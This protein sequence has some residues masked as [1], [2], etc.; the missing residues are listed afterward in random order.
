MA[1]KRM[2]NRDNLPQPLVD[3]IALENSKYSPGDSDI[4]VTQLIGSPRIRLL[5]K[6][7]RD[8][9]EEDASDML[10]RFFGQIAHGVIS[11]LPGHNRFVEER[12][13]MDV[14]G[15]KVGGQPDDYDENDII[16]DWKVTSKYAVKDGVKREWSDQIRSYAE[17]LSANGFEPKGGKIV[18]IL[19]DSKADEPKVKVLEV[20][21]PPHLDTKLYLEERVIIHQHAEAHG[22]VACSPEER[23]TK[24]TVWAV[25][26]KGRKSAVKLHSTKQD[27]LVMSSALNHNNKNHSVV[28]RPG[29][30][31][32]CVKYCEVNKWCDH[33]TDKLLPTLVK[34]RLT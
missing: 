25:M 17:L 24:P 23:W 6:A 13:Y 11:N 5:R 8:E 2:R 31:V 26:K 4:T 22:H 33:Y 32:K 7:H 10:W 28:E 14:L 30:D 12:L 1:Q 20:P 29:E 21:L 34:E 19:K 15:W 3:A 16:T 18:A 27:A 9:I